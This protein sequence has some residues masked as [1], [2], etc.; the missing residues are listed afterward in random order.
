[1]RGRRGESGEVIE[2]VPTVLSLADVG[3][4]LSVALVDGEPAYALDPAS[5]GGVASVFG[6]SG[7]V[8]AQPGDYE[9]SQVTND[10][11]VPGANV[12]LA[13]NGLLA[14]IPTLAS[15][16]GNDSNVPG[17]SVANA[18]NTLFG[19]RLSHL[20]FVDAAAPPTGGNGSVVNPFELVQDAV[21]AAVA[22]SVIVCMPGD[23]SG[24]ATVT[25]ANKTLCFFAYGVG[26]AGL[27]IL[28]VLDLTGAGNV[29]VEGCQAAAITAPGAVFAQSAT[30]GAVTAPTISIR[31]S[32]FLAAPVLTGAV[33]I[34]LASYNAFGAQNGTWSGGAF[35]I[36]DAEPQNFVFYV[37]QNAATPYGNGS[38]AAPFKTLTAAI[39]AA[40]VKTV[41]PCT[42]YVDPGDYATEGGIAYTDKRLSINGS[43]LL[44]ES[45]AVPTGGIFLR[46]SSSDASNLI[47]ELTRV[48]S[49]VIAQTFGIIVLVQD[50]HC[51]FI[52]D[53]VHFAQLK[54]IGNSTDT[55][56]VGTGGTLNGSISGNRYVLS[57][58]QY[59][60]GFQVDDGVVSG[61]QVATLVSQV[62]NVTNSVIEASMTVGGTLNLYNCTFQNIGLPIAFSAGVALNTDLATYARGITAGVTWPANVNIVD[63]NV[64]QQPAFFASGTGSNSNGGN[65]TP[66]LPTNIAGDLFVCRVNTQGGAAPTLPVGWTKQRQK[67]SG[68]EICQVWTRD[69]RAT[70]GESGTIVVTGGGGAPVQ[71]IIDSWRFVAMS[72]FIESIVDGTAAGADPTTVPGPTVTPTGSGRTAVLASFSNG[73]AVGT[74]ACT[75]NTGGTWIEESTSEF[76]SGIGGLL[77]MQHASLEP[78]TAITGGTYSSPGT[79]VAFI[80]FAFVGATA[81]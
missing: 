21:N 14:L 44:N 70:G 54:V 24:Q 47:L 2:I 25:W 74:T 8:T 48:N 20:I 31:S 9:A 27:A 15:E 36:V 73:T 34:D 79:N 66:G 17:A 78:S 4:I 41:S 49:N 37:S 32:S 3:K 77:A 35:N 30:L 76:V 23:Y 33:N 62:N 71:A 68:I 43:Q 53:G 6:R 80:A 16:L 67:T 61:A 28:P 29:S 1:M 51:E 57:A 65:P 7:I 22:G 10:S 81:T 13:L 72:A 52:S 11:S 19:T 5:P 39:A 59:A 26:A 12:K 56:N 46:P 42:I 50:A 63:T 64:A 55:N 18:L 60:V 40:P 38:A 69:T 75:G 45:P 58:G